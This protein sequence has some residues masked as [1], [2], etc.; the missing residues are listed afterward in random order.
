M[1]E[2]QLKNPP[3]IEALVE[4]KWELKEKTSAGYY[5]PHYQLLLGTFYQNIKSMY[6]FHEALP[7]SEIPDDVTGSVVKHR[8]RVGDGEWPLVQIGPGIITINETEKYDT[9]ATFKPKAIGVV[10]ALFKS[11][12]NI[13]D[14]K[15]SSLQ[16]RYI[17]GVEFDYSKEN[18]C[19]FISNKMHIES[20]TPNC[21]IIQDNTEQFPTRYSL[22]TTLRCSTPPG[23]ASFQVNT[24]HRFKQR[25]VIWNQ[26]FESMEP[27][28]PDMPNGFDEWITKAHDVIDIWFKG[29][30]EGDLKEEFNRG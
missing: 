7:T 14:L 16:I 11:Y 8:F 2:E 22:G 1:P 25:A 10:K 20:K 6:P 29:I 13:K 19:E 4:I 9:F 26:I 18:I 24:G 15:I 12:P 28:L 23:I 27:D 30:I 21:L 17:D 3:I 5:D